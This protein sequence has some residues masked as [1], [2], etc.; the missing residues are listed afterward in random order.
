MRRSSRSPP[1]CCCVSSPPFVCVD[2]PRLDYFVRTTL[3]NWDTTIHLHRKVSSGLFHTCFP[4]HF[5][6]QESSIDVVNVGLI[7]VFTFVQL[8]TIYPDRH[9]GFLANCSQR[10]HL[11]IV[12]ITLR[13]PAGPASPSERP[14]HHLRRVARRHH[15]VSPISAMSATTDSTEFTT[16]PALKIGGAKE[17]CLLPANTVL[18]TSRATQVPLDHSSVSAFS[19]S[20]RAS[21]TFGRSPPRAI[22]IV[23]EDHQQNYQAPSNIHLR[24]TLR[25]QQ[26]TLA[27]QTT[28]QHD[29][30]HSDPFHSSPSKHQGS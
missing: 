30:T 6:I 16:P 19:S 4:N 21:M 15:H 14:Q 7:K 13:S 27:R 28:K 12:C 25:P 3:S 22:P 5:R 17:T 23:S 29:Q 2:P 9:H 1:L 18:A 20:T 24:P 26:H 10:F 8:F 11:F